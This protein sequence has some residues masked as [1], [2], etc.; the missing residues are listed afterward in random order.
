[1]TDEGIGR[2]IISCHAPKNQAK[3]WGEAEKLR[4]NKWWAIRGAK[5]W[6]MGHYF[7]DIHAKIV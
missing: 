5:H 7:R 4:W 3:D 6:L 2:T 1:M